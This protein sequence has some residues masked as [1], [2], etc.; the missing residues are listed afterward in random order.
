MAS[1]ILVPSAPLDELLGRAAPSREDLPFVVAPTQ[2]PLD[3]LMAH[4]R[5]RAAQLEAG[6]E[7]GRP[8]QCP[9][10]PALSLETAAEIAD[11]LGWSAEAKL[12][13]CRLVEREAID[14]E[15]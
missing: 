14:L 12:R 6:D 4:V 3:A 15:D 9:R 2:T 10:R 7:L 11:R 8:G 13:F 5:S 1:S